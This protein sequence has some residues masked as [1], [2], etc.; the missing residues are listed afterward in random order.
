MR[1]KQ[2]RALREFIRILKPS[3]R[4]VVVE[5]TQ[6]AGML[7]VVMGPPVMHEA[8][9]LQE[10]EQACFVLARTIHRR[11]DSIMVAKKR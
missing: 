10:M 6:S 2:A 8:D 3:G 1:S 9:I 11:N 7:A 5:K 4:L